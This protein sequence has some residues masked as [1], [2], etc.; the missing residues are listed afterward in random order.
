MAGLKFDI[1]GDNGNMLSALQGVQNGV[2]QTQRVVEQSGQGI[3]QAFSKVQSAAA[4]A[5]GAFSAKELVRNV[6][7]VRGQF[8]QLEVAFTTMLG[9]ADKAN[10]LMSQLVRTAATTP[11]DLKSVSEGAKQLLAY[12]TQ[13][14]EVNGTLIRLG[15][16]AAGL[17]I[18]LNDLVYL[19]GTTM[20]QG[21]MFT[22][23]LRQF[24]GRGIPIADELAK[25]FGVTKDKVGE[26]VTA[27][28]VGAAE[29]QQAIENMTNAGSRFGGL[30]EAQSHTIT[31]QISNIED[32]I[33]SMFNDIGKA[34][35]GVINDALGG[36]SYLVEHWKE[37]GQI[38]L[39]VAAA[40]GIAKA[41]V[42][43]WST[44]QKIHNLLMEKA[45]VQMALAK[46]EG[47]AM[48]E[49][50]A[51][52]S[53]AT[54]GFKNALNA[55]KVAIASNPVGALAV[56]LTT[57]FTAMQ[58][59]DDETTELA[60]ASNKYGE[61]AAKSIQKVKTLSDEVKGL[62]NSNKTVTTSTKFSK[63]VLEELNQVLDESGVARI[64]EGDSIDT[65]NKKREMA[66]SLIKEEAIERQRL[67]N[68]DAGNKEFDDKI[69]SAN[70]QLRKDLA[71][72][73]FNSTG[74]SLLN[75][76]FGSAD[77][78]REKASAIFTVISQTV[79]ENA[80]LV[81][82][83]TGSAYDKGLNEIYGKIR[84]KM[85]AMGVSK[86]A[87]D[88]TWTDGGW[89]KQDNLVQ[90]YID[91]IQG[92]TEA[93]YDYNKSINAVAEAE[94]RA[95]DKT[96]TF[97]DKVA[98]ISR[99]LQGPNDGVHQLYKNI[100]K[101][102]EKYKKNTIGFEIQFSGKVPAWM[103]K[104]GIPQLS[105]LA[106]RFTSLGES[107]KKGQTMN[108]NGKTFTKEQ[109]LQRGADYASA[110][111]A[112]QDKEDSAKNNENK[113]KSN[114]IAEQKKALQEKLNAL[115]YQE[116]AGRKGAE[117]RR[118]IN[119]L[120]KKEKVYSSSYDTDNAKEAERKAKEAERKAK[121]AADKAKRKAEE[122]ARKRE[123]VFE[124]NV[125]RKNK[126]EEDAIKAAEAKEEERIASITDAGEK[127]RAAYQLQYDKT[128]RQVRKEADDLRKAKYD[129][130]KRDWDNKNTD[131]TKVYSDTEEGKKN[132]KE[133]KLTT[134]QESYLQSLISKADKEYTA[135]RKKWQ[136]EEVDTLNSYLKEY[137][138]FEEK[139]LAITKEY[140][141]KMQN[142][143]SVGE[144]ATLQM[145][146]DK[147]IEK[148]KEDNINTSIDW[149]GI[150]S[151]LQGHTKDYLLGLRDQLQD[152]LSS[153]NLPID[154]MQVVSE[155]INAIDEELGKQQGIWNFIGE[156]ARE[157][158][159][160][161]KEAADAQ[162][163]L[164]VAR[165]QEATEALRLNEVKQE[166]QKQL[167]STGIDM[168]LDEISTSSL[169]GKIDLTDEKFKSMSPILQ[170]LAVA[171][172]KLAEARKNT[173]TT[174]NKAK[175]AEDGAKRKSAQAVADW[176]DKAQEFIEKKGIDQ[177]PDLLGS[178][179]L[180]KAGDK[181][182][183]GLDA[184]NSAAGA[185]GD[186][187]SGNYVG[188]ALKG[189]SAIK[190]FGSML[191]IGG[192]NEKEVAR[193]TE[194]LTKSNEELGKRIDSLSERIG[195][196]AGNKA[197]NAYETALK[198]QKEINA[199]SMEI[200]K[201]QMGYHSAHHSNNSYAS[202]SKIASY[203]EDAQRAF[204]A[205]GVDSANITGL[206]SIYSLSPEQLKAI[207]DFAPNLWKYLT[208]VGKYDK[209][210]YWD[211]VVEQA[212]KTEKLTEQ[213][214]NNLTQT[215]FDSLRSSF[216]D[217]LMDMNADAEDWSNNFAKMLF[218]S[219]VNRS[220]LN[221][222][223]DKWL[224]D[225][226][227]KWAKK[228]SDGDMSQSDYEAYKSEYSKKMEELKK[229]TDNLASYMGYSDE[230]AAQKAT[231]NGVSSIT[232]EQAT[233]II[234]LTTAGNISRD[235]TKELVTSIVSNIASLSS[236]SSSTSATIVE[237]RNLM[238][239]NNSYLED[240]LKN[241]KNIYN[242]FSSKIDDIN[243]NLKELK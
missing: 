142:A 33:D 199:N 13:A 223:F 122:A 112:K 239:T 161:L 99:A 77:E 127:E 164:N 233:N 105:S 163:R 121:E 20:T 182:S 57:V 188:A 81:A 190:S 72:A 43:A 238:I 68:I 25:I 168:S 210:E 226:Q 96:L 103:D 227:N 104:M 177:I 110:M 38:V 189:I 243:R 75:K 151:D 80:D 45:A 222:D 180:G 213:I 7:E 150:F 209:K 106:K 113:G 219:L 28:K 123:Y 46:A 35:E 52:A 93:H 124:S 36:V 203:N 69:N 59:L 74:E 118:K 21:R 171:E 5:A 84:A 73:T 231:A 23:D 90:K 66:I 170:K 200:L 216:L 9:S 3:E 11:F 54:M 160:R 76:I 32:A 17:S 242:V 135:Q 187:A 228:L 107:L 71:N 154:Q 65:V 174:T 70:E 149:N 26:L 193:T 24:Q 22:Q 47:I 34:N 184:L 202:D 140:E 129:E 48:S 89:L 1:T 185:A 87:L 14:D 165:N 183:K 131:K 214:K 194:R 95:A 157:H 148:A 115:S 197:I 162:E 92:A 205:A 176:F 156:K 12:G 236:F 208:E 6:L 196:S 133:I 221:D 63:D 62:S 240:I 224:K 2:R 10:D 136:Q 125:T 237:I 159:R 201:K 4:A 102:M 37:I 98:G 178:I 211:A 126:E 192:G 67:N 212:G 166:A 29:V 152:L 158:N 56:V 186:F 230:N 145:Q 173:I 169:N 155:K 27:G 191:G 128:I 120:A 109:L 217:T 8:Q 49:A 153:G 44:Y 204:A 132:Y 94:K 139:K 141:E 138:S 50:E 91:S 215:S 206:S 88:K 195:N 15:D 179:G 117:L 85:E 234:A 55:L 19:Y 58:L 116:A 119:A 100:Q 232:Y 101:L 114:P 137:G 61:S 229:K 175:Q 181:V 108:V 220:V 39:N 41:A 147:E 218:K 144:K 130:N 134:D 235:Q 167:S 30:M 60:T 82:N 78:V 31:G 146:R 86:A 97:S 64:K 207:R 143:K 18:P 40:Y 241:S 198:A 225:F 79:Q 51:M 83:K 53:V 42:V 172:A 16:I 111:K